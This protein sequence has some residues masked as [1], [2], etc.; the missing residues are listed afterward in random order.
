MDEHEFETFLAG[1]Y[2]APSGRPEQPDI[3]AAVVA[4][5]ARG[6][7]RRVMVLGLASAFGAGVLGAAVAATGLAPRLTGTLTHTLPDTALIDPSV[8]VVIGLALIL[9]AAA[10]NVVRDA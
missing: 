3:A 9:A 4:R 8:V 7:L 5:V 2:R 6:R 1:A 10:R